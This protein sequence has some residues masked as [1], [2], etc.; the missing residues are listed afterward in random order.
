MPSHSQNDSFSDFIG[1]IFEKQKEEANNY[2]G[3]IV[4]EQFINELFSILFPGYFTDR[5]FESR[6][7]IHDRIDIFFIHSKKLILPYLQGEKSNSNPSQSLDKIL[8]GFRDL[9]PS[10]YNAIWDDAK[11]AYNWDP[12]AESIKEVILAYPGF[13]AIAVYRIAHIFHQLGVPIFP[14]ILSEF[15]HE[16]TGIDIHPGAVIGSSFFHSVS[17]KRDKGEKLTRTR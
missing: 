12:A 7:E 17:E 11:A 14:R 10:S 3:R 13:F 16:K 1:K 5:R 4:G 9:L 2:G 8:E 6:D 15:A